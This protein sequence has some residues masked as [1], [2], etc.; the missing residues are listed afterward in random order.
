MVDAALPKVIAAFICGAL[1]ATLL[2]Y[3]VMALSHGYGCQLYCDGDL[4]TWLHY[5]VEAGWWPWP[6]FGG[7]IAVL[8]LL[9]RQRSSRSFRIEQ[10]RRI[11][12]SPTETAIRAAVSR[13]V[14][15]WEGL[16]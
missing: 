16:V 3:A 15:M 8:G 6:L 10:R 12:A 5:P 9:I 11:S 13:L 2:G 4:P 7:A 1:S 14:N